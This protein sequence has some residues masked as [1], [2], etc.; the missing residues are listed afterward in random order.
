MQQ[1]SLQDAKREKEKDFLHLVQVSAAS[2]ILYDG[3]R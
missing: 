2:Q 1:K 3:R